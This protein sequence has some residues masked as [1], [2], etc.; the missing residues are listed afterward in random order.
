MVIDKVSSEQVESE[1]Y[2]RITNNV[3]SMLKEL[4]AILYGLLEIKGGKGDVHF[5]VDSRSALES[6]VSKN[7]A[8]KDIEREENHLH[9]DTVSRRDN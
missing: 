4:C 3:S 1:Y 8:C 6:L 2:S 9:L 7:P 5:F